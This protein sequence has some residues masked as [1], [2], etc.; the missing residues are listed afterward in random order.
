MPLNRSSSVRRL[1]LVSAVGLAASVS[2]FAPEVAWAAVPSPQTWTDTTQVINETVPASVCEI[3]F[4]VSGGAGGATA[5]PGFE[6]DGGKAGRVVASVAV[7]PGQSF[8]LSIGASGDSNGVGGQSGGATSGGAGGDRFGSQYGGG[9]GGAT[10]VTIGASPTPVIVAAGGGGAGYASGAGGDAGPLGV[11]GGDGFSPTGG[12]GGTS[13]GAGL[14][15]VGDQAGREGQDGNGP[16]GGDGIRSS[17]GGG[18]GWYAGGA[19]GGAHDHGS[20][21]GGGANL[22]P[23]GASVNSTT[24]TGLSR[25]TA[26]YSACTAPPD[27]PTGLSTT[28]GNTTASLVFTPPVNDGGSAITSYE[29]STDNGVNWTTIPTSA[30]NGGTR[31]ASLSS[32]TNTTTYQV[33]VRARN[34]IGPGT[35]SSVS[36]VTP[37]L[38]VPGAPTG[39]STSPGNS[40]AELTFT[41][42][43]DDGG[44]SITRYEVSTDN[45]VNWSTI[46]TAPGNGGTRTATVSSLTNTTTY[47]VKV[48]A[49]NSVGDGAAST[50]SPVTPAAQVPGAPT[51]LSTTPGNTSATLTF[52]PPVDNGGSS[53]TSYEVSTDNGANWATIA[54]SPAGGGT[55]TAT[56]TS[57]TNTTTYQVK[58]RARN[59]VGP[60]AESTASPVTPGSVAPD[61]PTGLSTTPGNGSAALVF[62]PPVNDGGSAITSY[63]VSTDNGVNWTTIAT[64]AGNGGT[65]TAT[66]TGLTNTTTYQIKVRARN[67][68][69]PGAATSASPTTPAAQVPGA[70]T[71]VSTTPG[72]GSAALVFTPPADDGGSTITRYEVSTD[73]GV[74]W[75]TIATSAGNGGTRT[76]TVTGLTN[77][78]TYQVKVR[79]VNSVGDGAAST[80][81]SVTPAPVAP[82]APTGLTALPGDTT[83]T[84]TFT[85]PVDNGGSA[86]TDYQVSTDN[87][88]NWT[89]VQTTA[90][91]S[92]QRRT[93]VTSLTNNQLYQVRVRA[94]NGVGPG[95]QSAAATVTPEAPTPPPAAP[96]TA[97]VATAGISSIS[98]SWPAVQGAVN[99]KAQA[100]PGNAFCQ[101]DAPATSCVLGG[102]AGTSYTVTVV[103]IGPGGTSLPS[104]A[105]NQVTVQEPEPPATVPTDAPLTLTTDK[106]K[107]ALAVPSQQIVVIG[108]GFAPYSTAKVTIYSDPIE[109]GTV[110][111]DGNG[112]F[113]VP[114]TV[115]AA[116][117]AG[118]HTFLAVGVDPQGS[119][120]KM[121]LPVTVPPTSPDTTGPGDTNKTTLPVPAG[122]GITLLDANNNPATTVVIPQQGT[123]AL[124]ATT[125]AIT[126]VPV[127]G[128]TGTATSVK[129]RITDSIGTMVDGTYTAVVT[130]G[131]GENPGPG[132]STGSVTVK[133]SKLTVTRGVPAKA[134]VP[135]AVSFSA[136]VR[137]RHTVVL[138]STV[139]G[140][141]VMLGT[142]RAVTTQASRS[143]VVTVTLNPLGRA[144]AARLG[145]YPIAAA[146]TTVPTGGGKTLRGSSR[147]QLVLNSFTAARPVYFATASSTISAPQRRY[148]GTLRSNL[149]GIRS[150]TCVGHTDDRGSAAASRALG[151]RR[152]REVCRTLAA[153]AGIRT[154]VITKG[155]ANPSGSNSTAA[156]MARNRRVDIT[157]RY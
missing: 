66:V 83:A 147:T 78:T 38:Q 142:G 54:T 126:F 15:G 76:A 27:A 154:Y 53:I 49:V 98:V 4:D 146:I 82:G 106:G 48:R 71:G 18:G 25:V 6:Q 69:G 35:A 121:A 16:V 12:G 77:T 85:P 43:V 52:T 150:I 122:G 81:S 46:V 68:V 57:L 113:S 1:R 105:S 100:S 116:L 95:T 45:G 152:A 124:D 56:V 42:P 5:F 148:L 34:A 64:S 65:R 117:A 102:V 9:G 23:G 157:I 127:T 70:P 97:P 22:A 55:R 60:G 87:G 24:T 59:S 63:E 137:G 44:S 110:T 80:A 103:A 143:A 36:P 29:V 19:G 37:D 51:G 153:R 72:N 31:T 114:V 73:N 62:T 131:G 138:W 149:T 134:T 89:T 75:A 136:A 104:A 133:V 86:I 3:E 90:F 119:S 33:K 101:V 96:A 144:M 115:P 107:L 139:S 7:T 135:V 79:A 132:P 13:L 93:T 156:G 14:G 17:G 91:G 2:V 151:Q 8:T 11:A 84:V 26:T 145:G 67:A 30:G 50:A 58:V 108:T 141:R 32:L 128:F 88:V 130:G 155:E 92:T 140:K 112:N 99:Y 125:G 111:T 10:F 28:P 41:P 74:N 120:R 129:Y 118:P 123:Y 39:L 94:V 47:Q 109:L 20:G 40:S 61:A 21:G